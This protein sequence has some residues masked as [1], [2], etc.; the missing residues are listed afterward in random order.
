M[1]RY[2]LLFFSLGVATVVRLGAVSLSDDGITFPDGTKQNT[3]APSDSRCAFYLTQVTFTGDQVTGTGVC[4]DGFHF[5][6]M[7]EIVDVSNLK[8]DVTR[9]SFTGDSGEGPIVGWWG[10]VWT[11]GGPDTSD[12]IGSTNCGA[13]FA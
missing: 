2:A 1:K 11:G 4:A 9:G 13:V 12:T 6:S 5:A 10:C 3:S 8:W 7:W